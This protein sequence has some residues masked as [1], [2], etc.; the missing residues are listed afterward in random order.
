MRINEQWR[1]NDDEKQGGGIY[2]TRPLFN[3]IPKIRNQRS[4]T[5]GFDDT[6]DE[7]TDLGEFANPHGRQR[8]GRQWK[9]NYRGEDEYK[10]KVSLTLMVIL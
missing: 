7:E 3:R 5:V 1:R 4:L 10:L 6:L 2:P 8:G 9:L